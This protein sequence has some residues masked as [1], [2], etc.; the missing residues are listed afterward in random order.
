MALNDASDIYQGT[1]VLIKTSHNIVNPVFEGVTILVT[2][3]AASTSDYTDYIGTF[4][5]TEITADPNNLFVGNDNM[6]YFPTADMPIKGMRGWF[7]VH[8]V[9]VGAISRARI[10]EH[11]NV[12]T[13]VELVNGALPSEFGGK[14]LKIIEN[15]QL[16]IIL[17]GV[18]YNAIG[19]RV[20]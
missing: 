18:Q 15:G 10:I 20:K 16:T 9:S 14:P 12:T 5:K 6:L 17:N 19:I 8:G 1:P 11:G 13:E 4:I 2:T 7:E 3:P